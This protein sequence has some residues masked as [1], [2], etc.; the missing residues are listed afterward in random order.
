MILTVT[1]FEDKTNDKGAW[2]EITDEKGKRH[3]L[4]GN[5][6]PDLL[7]K[8]PLVQEG[9]TCKLI[10]VQNGFREYD[11][12]QIANWETVDVELGT[13]AEAVKKEESSQYTYRYFEQMQMNRRTALMQAV[14]VYCT[15]GVRE[16][17]VLSIAED[18]VNWLEK[19]EIPTNTPI[20]S[21]VE[22]ESPYP[23][24]SDTKTPKGLDLTSDEA[25]QKTVSKIYKDSGWT[26]VRFT[27]FINTNKDKWGG[28]VK[29]KELIPGERIIF[30]NLLQKEAKV[31][32]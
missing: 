10:K 23:P 32:K 29:W 28:K 16:F 26:A 7:S 9:M 12:K 19:G 14:Q 1:K 4:F 5:K 24:V 27:E 13:V 22:A 3:Q 31:A 2:Y 11:G 8:R 18:F 20:A 21:P 17:S 15:E 6:I 25:Y 30:V